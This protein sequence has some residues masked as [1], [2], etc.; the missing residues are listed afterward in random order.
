MYQ[1]KSIKFIIKLTYSK[2]CSQVKVE[3]GEKNNTPVKYRY[4]IL[5]LKKSSVIVLLCYYTSLIIGEGV[6][7]GDSV[8]LVATTFYI[9]LTGPL[10]NMVK[11]AAVYSGCILGSPPLRN[12]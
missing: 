6:R 3:V 4:S 8:C 9:L 5:V 7:E 2:I 1:S 10:T 11:L 12:C